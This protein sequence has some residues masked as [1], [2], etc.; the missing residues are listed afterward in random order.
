MEN[1]CKL[2]IGRVGHIA[3]EREK[4]IENR[5]NRKETYRDFLGSK[6]KR[7]GRW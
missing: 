1:K 6:Y 7:G 3:S 4:I 5:K 2:Q